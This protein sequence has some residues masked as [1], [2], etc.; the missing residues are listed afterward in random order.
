MPQ[1]RAWRSST[2]KLTTTFREQSRVPWSARASRPGKVRLESMKDAFVAGLAV[3]NAETW[4][5]F[6]HLI[7]SGKLGADIDA[8]LRAAANTS[9]ADLD[10]AERVRRAFTDEVDRTLEDAEV[11]VL[12]TMPSLPITLDAA[13]A[14][15]SVI[16]M[17]SLIRPFNLSGHPA[18]T[19]PIPIEQ[20]RMKAGLQIVGRKGRGRNGVQRGRV[21]RGNASD[22]DAPTAEKKGNKIARRAGLTVR[23][24]PG[25]CR[26]APLSRRRPT[27]RSRYRA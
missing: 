4:R 9:A 23:Y 15:T 27:P 1:R 14:G 2:S 16:A 10:A 11:I 12:P 24:R 6:G 26:R 25:R 13:R 21:H 17:S 7:A 20:S 3:I 18:L 8:R 5:A 19:L 22:V